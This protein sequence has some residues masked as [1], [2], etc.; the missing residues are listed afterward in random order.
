MQMWPVPSVEVGQT[1][2]GN[3]KLELDKSETQLGGGGGSRWLSVCLY[4]LCCAVAPKRNLGNRLAAVC[5][6]GGGQIVCK[7]IDTSRA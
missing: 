7:K 4:V 1:Q 2:C 6:T 3:S 5:S